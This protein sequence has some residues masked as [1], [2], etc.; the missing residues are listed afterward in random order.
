MK[1]PTA[2]DLFCG[3]GG[4]TQG[5]RDAG[6]SV[7]GAV[8]NDPVA[9]ESYKMNHRRV[10]LW[11]R[12]IRTLEVGDLLESLNLTKGELDLMAGCPPCQGFSSI[13]TLQGSKRVRDKRNDLICEF[14]RLVR[15]MLPK[16]VML[17]NVPGLKKSRKFLEFRSEL[18]SLGYVI[19]QDI[20]DAADFAVPQRR[21]RLIL[22]ASRIGDIHM[23][24]KQG[25]RVSVGQTIGGLPRPG[26]SKDALHDF[27]ERRSDKVA[28][29][30]KAIPKNGGSR[31]DL[32]AK[33]TLDCHKNFEG[34]KDVYGRMAWNDVAPTIT[35]GCVNPSKG[36]FVHPRQNRAITLREAALLQSF[37]I[38]YR[39]S[40]R[41]GKHHVALMIGNALPPKFIESHATTILQ[42]IRN[43][44]RKST[45]D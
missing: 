14:A 8:D 38:S 22:I 17:E 36:R 3:C 40:L 20:A 41:K 45:N 33:L 35:G 34:F 5:L 10:K 24:S 19:K 29:I 9:I 21:K 44:K 26:R 12:D 39:F 15:G 2:I 28:A 7:L 30:I 25:H 13:R 31:S 43:A 27:P 11:T 1:K 37:P 42:S 4:L 32:S 16:T 6:F 23:P 18:R